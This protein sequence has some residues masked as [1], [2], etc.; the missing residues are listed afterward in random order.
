MEMKPAEETVADP[1]MHHMLQGAFEKA[2]KISDAVLQKNAG[3]PCW[4]LPRHQQYVWN[5]SSLAG[6]RV[7]IRCYHGLGDTLQF[8]RYAP[9]VRSIAKEVIVWAQPELLPLLQTVSGIDQLLP[10]HDG[11]PGVDYDVD[12]EVMELPHVFRTTIATIPASIPYLRVPPRQLVT[13]ESFN[14]GL[15]W[16]AGDWDERRNIPFKMLLP[17]FQIPGV[18]IYVLQANASAAGYIP[19]RGICPGNMSLYDFA[20]TVCSLDLM[21]SVDSMPAHLAGALGVPVIT[22]LHAAADWRWMQHTSDSP[23]YPTMKLIRQG[24]QQNWQP[25]VDKLVQIIQQYTLPEERIA[26]EKTPFRK[27]A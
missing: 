10:L 22:L 9:L 8:I 25:V 4:H 17:L 11:A 27:I 1:W 15:V 7:L 18:T 13:A 16:K 23:W 12:V 6:K 26:N 21:I 14:V 20:Q 24:R 3:K 5:G 19:G 2:W